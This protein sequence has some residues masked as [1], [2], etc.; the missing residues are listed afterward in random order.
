MYHSGCGGRAW[1][2]AEVSHIPGVM[3]L[4]TNKL[5][6]FGR[7]RSSITDFCATLHAHPSVLA[8]PWS[9]TVVQRLTT[10]EIYSTPGVGLTFFPIRAS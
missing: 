1:P 4:I 7:P 9:A 8:P 6:P 10:V 2:R 5:V 3:Q